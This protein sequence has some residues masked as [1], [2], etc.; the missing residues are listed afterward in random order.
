MFRNHPGI[1]IYVAE[2]SWNVTQQGVVRLGQTGTH[3]L[4]LKNS[5]SKFK[6]IV[7][8]LCNAFREVF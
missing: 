7:P 8:P 5:D 3:T 4:Y 1:I 2:A 6:N